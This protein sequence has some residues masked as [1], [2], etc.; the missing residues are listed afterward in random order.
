MPG[1]IFFTNVAFYPEQKHEERKKK[2]RQISIRC[3]GQWMSENYT[4]GTRRL[5]CDTHEN[6]VTPSK[7]NGIT[8]RFGIYVIS[9]RKGRLRMVGGAVSDVAGDTK[10]RPR[11][12]KSR[13]DEEHQDDKAASA[14]TCGENAAP[15][16][17][18]FR[19]T[20][21]RAS[22]RKMFVRD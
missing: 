10:G 14:S 1:G 3:G 20:K 9:E 15:G 16:L 17:V 8:W 6:N 4:G 12:L 21:S 2:S 22:T 5:F 7:Q 18:Y 19:L 11:Y 13:K